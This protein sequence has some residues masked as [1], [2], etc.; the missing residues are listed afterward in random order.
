MKKKYESMNNG[1]KYI[2][3]WVLNSLIVLKV[4]LLEQWN[5]IVTYEFHTVTPSLT[6]HKNPFY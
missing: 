2:Y 3:R 6:S 4:L 1:K 5:E